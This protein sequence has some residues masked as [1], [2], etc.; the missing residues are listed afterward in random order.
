MPETAKRWFISGTVQG[1]GFRFFVQKKA[2]LLGLKGWA[3]NLDDGRVE[4]YAVGEEGSL[5]DLAGALHVGPRMAEIRR[6]ESLDAAPER[7]GG[8]SIR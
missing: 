4:V 6:V 7:V 5:D 8:F 3:R 1:V 2:T